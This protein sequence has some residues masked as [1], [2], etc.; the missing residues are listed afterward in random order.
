MATSRNT[1]SHENCNEFSHSRG[2]CS[3]HYKVAAKSGLP[4]PP[5][6]RAKGVCAVHSCGKPHH[7]HGL[8]QMHFARFRR[9][10]DPLFTKTA[11]EGAGLEFLLAH[12]DH[13]G[14][15]CV[16]WPYS[17]SGGGYGQTYYNGNVQQTHRLMCKLAH[18]EPPKS[19][20]QAAHRCGN[21]GCINP[22]HLRWRTCKQNIDEKKD[23]GREALGEARSSAKLKEFEVVEIIKLNGVVPATHLAKKYGVNPVTIRAIQTGKTWVHI[24]R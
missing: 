21:H 9:H 11:P 12:V 22:R 23:H 3:R 17:K 13:M 6:S 10:G 4:L 16:E 1:C 2:L 24:P 5:R 18:G 8:C 19:D 20:L 14:S 7:I 15:D